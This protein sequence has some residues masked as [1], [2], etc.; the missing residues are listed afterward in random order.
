MQA[1]K[2]AATQSKNK[3]CNVSFKKIEELHGRDEYTP[4]KHDEKIHQRANW[5][6]ERNIEKFEEVLSALKCQAIT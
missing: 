5:W 3:V 6:A 2:D 1:T 4:Q